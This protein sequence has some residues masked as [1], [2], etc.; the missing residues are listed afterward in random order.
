[1]RQFG[2][3]PHVFEVSCAQPLGDTPHG[4]ERLWAPGTSAFCPVHVWDADPVGETGLGLVV[5]PM[6]KASFMICC[7]NEYSVTLAVTVTVTVA[8]TVKL[9]ACNQSS[10]NVR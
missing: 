3:Q 2:A 5:H 6:M 1:V 9:D 4:A 10:N 7:D 8:T